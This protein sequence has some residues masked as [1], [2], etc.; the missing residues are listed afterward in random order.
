MLLRTRVGDS[1]LVADELLTMS[2]LVPLAEPFARTIR[3]HALLEL[4]REA[5]ST[6]DQ[7]L[8][9]AIAAPAGLWLCSL[10][11][12]HVQGLRLLRGGRAAEASAVYTALEEQERRL[13]VREP[14]TVPYARHAVVAH[15]RSGRLREAEGVVAGLEVAAAALPCPWPPAAPAAGGALIALHDG[16]RQ[17]AHALYRSAVDALD[18]ASLPR[19]TPRCCSSWAPCCGT[20]AHGRGPGL[21][22]AGRRGGGGRR[23]GMAVRLRG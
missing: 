19:S 10:R 9:E 23:S 4:G 21:V 12:Q 1:L 6:A 20:T 5:G 8:A 14:C 11:L 15:L 22:P 18:G 2:D 17:E 7:Q 16:Q 3:S 13:G